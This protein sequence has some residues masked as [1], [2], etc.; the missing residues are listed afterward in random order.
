MNCHTAGERMSG[1]IDGQLPAG[2]A[3]AL[4]AHLSDCAECR[5]M[6]DGLRVQDAELRRAF[7]PGRQAAQQ[8]ASRVLES[9]DQESGTPAP[10]VPTARF[11]WGALILA[12]AAGFLLAVALFQ[13]WK[14]QPV[15]FERR[16]TVEAPQAEPPI[17]HLVVATGDVEMRAPPAT[18]WQAYPQIKAFHCPSGS[19]VRTGADVRCEL[20]TSDG[21]VIR[22]NQDT[23]IAL[24]SSTAVTIRR[25][26]IWCSSPDNVS[27]KIVASK[28]EAPAE[29]AAAPSWSFA[30]PSSSC[31]LT[32]ERRGGDVQVMTSAGETELQTPQGTQRL[33][34]GE[35]AAIVNGQIVKSPQAA[36]PIL[37]SGWVNSLLVRKGRNDGELARR[38]DE[39]LFFMGRSKVTWLYEQ[40]IRG[41][42]EYAVLPL[43]RF[44]QSPQSREEPERRLTAMRLL[45]DLASSWTAPELIALLEDD[46]AEIRVLAAAALQRLTGLSQGRPPEQWREGLD[47]CAATVEL[48]K[49]WWTSNRHQYPPPPVTNSKR[50]GPT[51]TSDTTLKPELPLTGS[52]FA[53]P[54]PRPA[55]F[56]GCEDRPWD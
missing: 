15:A 29:P 31:L 38:I 47:K 55:T 26:Q 37:E 14:R 45:R 7:L 27:L 23:E 53:T 49:Q 44:V 18:D 48:W 54:A 6:A 32:A 3:L 56:S 50:L 39:M 1:W 36:D 46:D 9:L 42:G 41:L 11:G 13:P 40:E 33:K 12:V 24:A 21:C 35:R 19:E 52:Y 20:Q 5:S 34:P 30:C 8:V 17:A 22:L 2:E 25:G 43:L 28:V 51:K 4:E 10:T 16:E